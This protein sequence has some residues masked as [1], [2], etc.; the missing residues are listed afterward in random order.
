M[1]LYLVTRSHHYYPFEGVGDWQAV[2]SDIQ[3]ARRKFE[4]LELESSQSKYLIEITEK[5]WQ[6]LA[7]KT[8][9]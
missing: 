4:D 6:V 5:G 2:S 1:T 8:N 7:E 9:E 3:E